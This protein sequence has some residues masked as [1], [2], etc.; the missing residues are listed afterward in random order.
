M[1]PAP[2]KN[3]ATYK[4]N[5]QTDEKHSSTDERFER[6]RC[7]SSVHHSISKNEEKLR[8]LPLMVQ[9]KATRT[10]HFPSYLPRLLEDGGSSKAGLDGPKFAHRV[11]LRFVC[12]K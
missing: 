2:C 9:A 8:D 7:C 1:L 11:V 3:A 5:A 12:A 6:A 4:A 10:L